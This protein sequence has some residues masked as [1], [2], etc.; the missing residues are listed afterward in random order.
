MVSGFTEKTFRAMVAGAREAVLEQ[1]LMGPEAW[2][3]GI[4]G[5]RRAAEPDG[6][7]VYCFFKGTAI[8]PD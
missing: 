3:R 7:F 1:G 5:L 6:T 4:A 8:C 2:E